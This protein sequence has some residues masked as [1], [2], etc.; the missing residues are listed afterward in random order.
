MLV[1]GY[2]GLLLYHVAISVG[3][4][5]GLLPIMGIPL[6][7]MS[8]GGSSILATLL[9]LGLCLSVRLRRFVAHSGLANVRAAVRIAK[10]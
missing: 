4:V 10:N 5:V 6:P 1:A 8:H 7:L 3:M 9:A 2:T